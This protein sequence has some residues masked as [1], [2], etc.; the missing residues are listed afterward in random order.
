MRGA[1]VLRSASSA[2]RT[3]VEHILEKQGVVTT[4]RIGNHRRCRRSLVIPN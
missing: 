4:F 2:A 1:A 3:V